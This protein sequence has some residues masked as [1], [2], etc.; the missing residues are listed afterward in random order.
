[1][2]A[3]V[4]N[5]DRRQLMAA[6]QNGRVYRSFGGCDMWAVRAGQNKRVERRLRELIEAGW[7]ELG[8]DSRTYRL[9]A[10]GDTALVMS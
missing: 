4:I 8:T 3:P 10:A 5:R 7:A 9:T 6:I 1:M 2:S